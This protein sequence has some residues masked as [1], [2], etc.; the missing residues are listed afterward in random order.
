MKTDKIIADNLTLSFFENL[1]D[2]N[3]SKWLTTEQA[4][5]YMGCS[6]G[7]L[8]NRV[9]RGHIAV[10]K[11]FGHNGRCF[12]KRDELDQLLEASRI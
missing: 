10:Y 8:R 12:F 5:I 11:P 4:A 9:Y 6:Q 2:R 7:S 1:I 3:R